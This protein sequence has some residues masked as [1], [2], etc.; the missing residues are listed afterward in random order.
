[1]ILCTVST[2]AAVPIKVS[3]TEV[4]RVPPF[5]PCRKAHRDA[6]CY[7]YS[8]WLLRH[9]G[10]ASSRF[11]CMLCRWDGY[12]CVA[13]DI[14]GPSAW[15]EWDCQVLFY[16]T[17]FQ[18]AEEGF[19]ISAYL[20]GDGIEGEAVEIWAAVKWRLQHITYEISSRFGKYLQLLLEQ[21]KTLEGRKVK[22]NFT[23]ATS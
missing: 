12:L 13:W 7:L 15:Q 3:S 5:T 6:T 8:T 17:A 11:L 18:S 9:G 14:S 10:T 21:L 22:N 16:S 19:A 4:T 1:M 23:Y 20:L 2:H